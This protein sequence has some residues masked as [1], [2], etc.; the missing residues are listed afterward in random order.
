M[1]HENRKLLASAART[2]AQTLGPFPNTAKGC[3]L[4]IDVTSITSTPILTPT[5][6]GVDAY[7]V[8]YTVLTG[9]AISATGTNVLKVFP[10]AS[11]V[12][13]AVANDYLPPDW[14][15]SIAVADADSATYS[16]S[17]TLFD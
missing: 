13:N 6:Q 16:V 9:A 10:G 4:V 14:K 17:V 12:A 1:S 11:P 2:T 5:I 7:G 3:H 8:T 15:V